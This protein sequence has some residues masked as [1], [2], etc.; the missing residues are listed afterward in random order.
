LAVPDYQ[1]EGCERPCHYA[2]VLVAPLGGRV[3]NLMESSLEPGASEENPFEDWHYVECQRNDLAAGITVHKVETTHKVNEHVNERKEKV[4]PTDLLMAI[5]D[6]QSL[7]G[8]L[9]PASSRALSAIFPRIRRIT[10]GG[11]WQSLAAVVA[12]EVDLAAVDA[13]V[14]ALAARHRPDMIAQVHLVGSTPSAPCMPYVVPASLSGAAT[15][16]MRRALAAAAVDPEAAQARKALLLKGLAFPPEHLEERLDLGERL[17]TPFIERFVDVARG[18]DGDEDD[19]NHFPIKTENYFDASVENHLPGD[20]DMLL[21][22]FRLIRGRSNGSERWRECF[23]RDGRFA[24]VVFFGRHPGDP[25]ES[26]DER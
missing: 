15:V 24:R 19:V 1:G 17:F 14:L 12:G 3:I 21:D 9:L 8:C 23:L 4:L 7:S 5:N 10:T 26:F 11:H 25:W 13:V 20:M 6:G 2:S 16:I 22:L 18:R